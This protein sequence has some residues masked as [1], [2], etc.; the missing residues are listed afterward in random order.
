MIK[1]ILLPTTF[2][3]FANL[4][5]AATEHTYKVSWDANPPDQQVIKYTVKLE[6]DSTP[7]PLVDVTSGTEHLWTDTYSVGTL[8][9]ASVQACDATECSNYSA[10]ASATVPA[11][12]LTVPQNVELRV[13]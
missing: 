2:L 13:Q 4:A 6:I 7:L 12:S 11:D 1:L 8:I 3:I 5:F 9:E 10:K